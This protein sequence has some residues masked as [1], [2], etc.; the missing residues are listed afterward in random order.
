MLHGLGNIALGVAAGQGPG[1]RQCLVQRAAEQ[2]A[3]RHAQAL[4]F[5]IEQRRFH[6]AFGKAVALDVRFQKLH[7][8]RCV[9]RL[10]FCSSSGAI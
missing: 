5:A 4:G 7:R 3:Q 8:L 9:F 2:R 6:R 1:H 10:L